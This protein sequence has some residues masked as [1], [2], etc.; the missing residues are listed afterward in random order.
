MKSVRF[1]SVLLLAVCMN[2]G[3]AYATNNVTVQVTNGTQYTMTQFYASASDA[4]AWNMT[5]N[6]I[7]GQ[8]LA[9][10]QS[11]TINIGSADNCTFDLMAVLYG[12]AQYAYK[13]TVNPCNGGTW[14]ITQGQ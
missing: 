7:A 2:L 10:G 1:A 12:A 8:S 5:N 4:T 14:T 3:N 9:P 13:Y 11:M 6:L